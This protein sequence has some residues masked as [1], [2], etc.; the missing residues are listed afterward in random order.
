MADFNLNRKSVIILILVGFILLK[1]Y[2]NNDILQT[3]VEILL[4]KTISLQKEIKRLNGDIDSI[5]PDRLNYKEDDKQREKNE[6][7]SQSRKE[8][9]IASNANNNVIDMIV[10]D[11]VNNIN[12]FLKLNDSNSR[13]LARLMLTSLKIKVND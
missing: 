12:I 5:K 3:D 9:P 13:L 10:D 6:E 2:L 4:K 8:A 11:L 7:E 1:M